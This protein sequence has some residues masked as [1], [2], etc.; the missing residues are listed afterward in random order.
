MTSKPSFTG[1]RSKQELPS[2]RWK[3]NKVVCK[4]GIPGK[5]DNFPRWQ[6]QA[7]ICSALNNE[8]R[9][10][11]FK[12]T[13]I[14]TCIVPNLL[15]CCVRLLDSKSQRVQCTL[16]KAKL[17]S[18]NLY[19]VYEY[20]IYTYIYPISTIKSIKLYQTNKHLS[21]CP[22]LDVFF[23]WEP[24]FPSPASR[25]FKATGGLNTIVYI[26]YYM[27]IIYTT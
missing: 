18:K 1:R 10:S 24:T 4:D 13:V 16:L 8:S 2:P 25:W 15:R 23:Q 27:K 11:R 9:S 21:S 22:I 14:K 19:T 6:V 12:A 26:I 20:I 5:P 3:T 17:L 7:V